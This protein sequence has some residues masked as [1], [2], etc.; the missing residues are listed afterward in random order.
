MNWGSRIESNWG[1][2]ALRGVPV[3]W[4]TLGI[5]ALLWSSCNPSLP[6]VPVFAT[7]CDDLGV[8]ED[9]LRWNEYFRKWYRGTMTVV[10]NKV[11]GQGVPVVGVTLLGG[12]NAGMNWE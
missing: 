7:L 3:C 11:H 5:P 12:C 6:I 4:L 9:G 8:D 10:G 1:G 2:D